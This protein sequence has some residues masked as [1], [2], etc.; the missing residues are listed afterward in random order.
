MTAA[1]LGVLAQ[2]PCSSTMLGLGPALAAARV[3]AWAEATWLRGMTRAAMAAARTGMTTRSLTCRAARAMFTVISF[4]WGDAER[5]FGRMEWHVPA[6]PTL[7]PVRPETG[8]GDTPLN[9]PTS[10]PSTP[11]TPTAIAGL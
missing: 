2:A 7:P 4:S 11:N 8:G 9:R 1:Q 6:S 5:P 10:Y 3:G